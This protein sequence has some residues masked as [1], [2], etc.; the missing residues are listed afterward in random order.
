MK[1]ILK[2]IALLVITFAIGF[3]LAFKSVEMGLP[4][5]FFVISA[6]GIIVI[7]SILTIWWLVNKLRKNQLLQALTGFM[8]SIIL[9][10]QYFAVVYHQLG[11]MNYDNEKIQSLKTSVYFSTVTFTTLGYGDF[12]PV[13]EAR[14]FAAIEALL[15]YIYLSLLV[16]LLYTFIRKKIKL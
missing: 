4:P 12:R 11:L 15:G 8:I 6:T 1:S 13:E 3:L 9:I 16:S 5:R 10:I 2:T 14:M 7:L